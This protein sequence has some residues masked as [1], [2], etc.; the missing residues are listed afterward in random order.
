[1]KP[2]EIYKRSDRIITVIDDKDIIIHLLVVSNKDGIIFSYRDEHGIS[3]SGTSMKMLQF[4]RRKNCKLNQKKT[5][6]NIGE[7]RRNIYYR[8]EVPWAFSN[9]HDFK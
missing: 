7:F 2:S 1:M 4:L 3:K 9:A 6:G 5:T 8:G